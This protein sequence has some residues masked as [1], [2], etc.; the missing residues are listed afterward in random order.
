MV[1]IFTSKYRTADFEDLPGVSFRNYEFRTS[2]DAVAEKLRTKRDVF[3]VTKVMGV[4]A[5]DP[6]AKVEVSPEVQASLDA[7]AEGSGSVVS[8]MRTTETKDKKEKKKK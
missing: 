2:D 4:M 3:E 5:K 1:Y 8:G 6:E 7:A